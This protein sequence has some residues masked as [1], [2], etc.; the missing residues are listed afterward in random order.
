MLVPLGPKP[1]VLAGI[2]AAAVNPE[3][4]F[5]WVT[6]SWER[7]VQ[8]EVAKNQVPCVTSI[9]NAMLENHGEA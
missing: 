2:L 9:S 5:R 3:I 1:H 6:T 8:V 7:P 4:G